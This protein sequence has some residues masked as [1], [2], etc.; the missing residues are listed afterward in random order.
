MGWGGDTGLEAEGKGP[1]R[2]ERVRVLVW[3]DGH[4]KWG[5]DPSLRLWGIWGG[6][7]SRGHTVPLWGGKTGLEGRG[8]NSKQLPQEK[9]GA[10]GIPGETWFGIGPGTLT[11]PEP[12]IHATLPSSHKSAGLQRSARTVTEERGKHSSNRFVLPD[13]L[14][15]TLEVSQPW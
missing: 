8:S 14:F 5:S 9:P 3:G 4:Q 2:A 1:S 15:V 6:V 7:G 13:Q 10:G 11:S 12:H